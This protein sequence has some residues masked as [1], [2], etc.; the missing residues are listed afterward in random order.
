VNGIGIGV[1]IAIK[2]ES[3]VEIAIANPPAAT[4]TRNPNH[5]EA[6]MA[7]KTLS[8]TKPS[9]PVVAGPWRQGPK[10]EGPWR[11]GRWRQGL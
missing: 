5:G 4:G 11:Q 9:D 7:I 6:A 8:P 2:I 3:G 1:W 10:R